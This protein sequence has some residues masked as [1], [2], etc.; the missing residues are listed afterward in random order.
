MDHRDKEQAP[1]K[2]PFNNSKPF[3]LSIGLTINDVYMAKLMKFPQQKKHRF[4]SLDKVSIKKFLGV[5]V[6][7][8]KI[9]LH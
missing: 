5:M 9:V 2:S 6:I 7:R 8:Q 3:Y 1:S 4:P